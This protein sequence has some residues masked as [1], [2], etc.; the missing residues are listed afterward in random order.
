MQ[1]RWLWGSLGK[2]LDAQLFGN[3]RPK[4]RLLAGAREAQKISRPRVV[5]IVV[6][7]LELFQVGHLAGI[8]ADFPIC[9]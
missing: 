2:T 5:L 8:G 4:E 7:N 1:K 3:H 6:L 9:R